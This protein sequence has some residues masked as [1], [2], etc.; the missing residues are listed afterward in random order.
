MSVAP[1]RNNAARAAD[2]HLAAALRS[3]ETTAI[4]RHERSSGARIGVD[5][6]N[7]W[8][9]YCKSHRVAP[10]AALEDLNIA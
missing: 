2:P 7:P 5:A 8:R 1:L 9:V 10:H 3:S 4:N 6:R